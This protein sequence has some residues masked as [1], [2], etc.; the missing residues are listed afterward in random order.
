[1]DFIKVPNKLLQHCKMELM[2]AGDRFDE[3]QNVGI[4][5]TGVDARKARF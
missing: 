3:L 1:M 4:S 2:N 5:D